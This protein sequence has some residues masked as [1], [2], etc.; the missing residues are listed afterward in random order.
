MSKSAGCPAKYFMTASLKTYFSKLNKS[1]IPSHQSIGYAIEKWVA[2]V[3]ETWNECLD[4]HL[5]G[6]RWQIWQA[7]VG[8]TAGSRH[9]DTWRQ[10]VQTVSAD[11][12]RW[13]QGCV[14][15]PRHSYMTMPPELL[16]HISWRAVAAKP[17]HSTYVLM[18]FSRNRPR[19]QWDM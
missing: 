2:I 4:Q 13:C 16:R 12:W 14:P 17:N 15:F 9:W 5:H 18:G 3:Q 8:A 1:S 7:V 19:C 10:P 6:V 11:C